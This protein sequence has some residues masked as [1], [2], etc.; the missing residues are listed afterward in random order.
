MTLADERIPFTSLDEAVH[1]LDT[2]AE[3]WSIQLEVQVAGALDEAR[4]RA[5]I[6]T[7]LARH[8]MARARL[9]PARRSDKRWTWSVTATPDLDPLKVLDCADGVD[10]ARTRAELHSLSVP[11]AESPPLRLRLARRP[12]GDVLMINANHAA[13][14][15]FATLE[16][17]RS[18]ARAYAG[19]PEPEP[20]VELAEARDIERLTTPGSLTERA[21]RL[22]ALGDKALDLVVPPARLAAQ[23]GSDRPGYG[24]H[25]ISLPAPAQPW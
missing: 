11:L 5:A 8:P 13:L 16:V 14:D 18:I 15:G 20:G 19:E 4:L 1:L 12:L 2:P 9:L 22:R 21:R 7:A 17:L 23:G 3:P 24:I 10:L 25:Q 6:P